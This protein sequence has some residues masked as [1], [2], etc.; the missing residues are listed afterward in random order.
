MH[1]Y[2]HF[3]ALFCVLKRMKK[4]IKRVDTKYQENVGR[5]LLVQCILS[6]SFFTVG[7]FIHLLLCSACLCLSL[8]LPAPVQLIYDLL[9][10]HGTALL[11]HV[12][13]SGSLQPV[14]PRVP[15]NP[16]VCFTRLTEVKWGSRQNQDVESICLETPQSPTIQIIAHSESSK[17]GNPGENA[18]LRQSVQSSTYDYRVPAFIFCKLMQNNNRNSL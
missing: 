8:S 11:P 16:Q 3:K 13:Q 7:F 12:Y 15:F 9:S 1:F 6:T 10:A 17:S 2:N 4:R 18:L 5:C 14:Y